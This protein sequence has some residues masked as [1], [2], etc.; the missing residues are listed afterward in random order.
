M[1]MPAVVGGNDGLS[2]DFLEQAYQGDSQFT[3][4]QLW[5]AKLNIKIGEPETAKIFLNSI[6]NIQPNDI[7]Q[8]WIPETLEDQAEALK[9]LKTL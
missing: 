5:L 9:L 6:I 8:N 1:K 4:T 3:L 7:D 2:K